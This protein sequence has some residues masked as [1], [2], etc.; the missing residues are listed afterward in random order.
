M[1]FMAALD[2]VIHRTA[3]LSA[4]SSMKGFF[5]LFDAVLEEGRCE[6]VKGCEE[7]CE[8]RE[9]VV[10]LVQGKKGWV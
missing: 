3:K 8:W 4:T 5:D 6:V 9:C 7:E 1:K 2:L 10:L